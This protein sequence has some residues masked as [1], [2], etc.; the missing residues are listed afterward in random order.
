M[1]QPE[2]ART[3]SLQSASLTLS[4]LGFGRSFVVITQTVGDNLTRTAFCELP[5]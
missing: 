1:V 4:S 3:Q 2:S 5:R